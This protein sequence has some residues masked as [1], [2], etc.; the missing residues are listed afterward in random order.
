MIIFPLAQLYL[1]FIFNVI[2]F[3]S[4]QMSIP[5]NFIVTPFLNSYH[6]LVLNVV[7][8]IVHI[9]FILIYRINF[10]LFTHNSVSIFLVIFFIICWFLI[11][12]RYAICARF[13]HLYIFWCA[14]LFN[15]HRAL[16][17]SI[18]DLWRQVFH[19]LINLLLSLG[20]QFA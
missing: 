5:L 3:L 20:L 9:Y 7:L 6:G 15:N 18:A 17:F 11:S 10:H 4:I 8:L 16:R 13:L 19:C 1:F 2:L 14:S 12:G